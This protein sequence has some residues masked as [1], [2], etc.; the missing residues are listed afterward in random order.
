MGTEPLASTTRGASDVRQKIL[1]YQAYMRSRRYRRYERLWQCQLRGFR[2]LFVTHTATRLSGLCQLVAN[3]PPSDFIWSTDLNRVNRE[4]VWSAVW[5][6]GG[7]LH[8]HP[9]TILGSQAPDRVARPIAL[10]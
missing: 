9:E 1:N 2:L 8:D 3:M 7:R 4:G 5:F 6:R 10:C